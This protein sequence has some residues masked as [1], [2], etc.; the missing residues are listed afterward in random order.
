MGFALPSAIFLL[1]VLAALG[2][3]MVNIS[4]TS[5]SS[6]LLDVAGER[7]YQAANAGMEWARYR[8]ST[9]AT[10]ATA[11]ACPAG[12]GWNASTT[13][14]DFPGSLTLT[15]YRAS[16]ECR[17]AP[18]GGKTDVNGVATTVYEIRVTACNKPTGAQLLCPPANA[19]EQANTRSA[20]MGYVERQM[21]GLIGV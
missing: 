11:D 12:T 19:G 13:S 6:A 4:I 3:F 14:L 10:A 18:D 15:G 7:A 5:Q 16:V 9:N 1:V 8:I 20:E 21:Q 2:A 17:V